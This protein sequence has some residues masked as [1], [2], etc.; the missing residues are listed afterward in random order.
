MFYSIALAVS[1]N[2]VRTAA[3]VDSQI[4]AAVQG[5]VEGYGLEVAKS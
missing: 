1:A 3:G 4:K 5:D 2:P